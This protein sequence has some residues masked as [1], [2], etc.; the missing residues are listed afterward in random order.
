MPLCGLWF[1][2]QIGIEKAAFVESEVASRRGA[3]ANE[4]P[5]HRMLQRRA[6]RLL[7]KEYP[8]DAASQGGDM[9]ML[10]V[11]SGPELVTSTVPLPPVTD[12]SAE[13]R[14]RIL[15]VAELLF[16]RWSYTGVSIRDVTDMAKTRLGNVNYYFG[17]KQNL[18]FEVLRRRAEVLSAERIKGIEGA[19]ASDLSGSAYIEAL[20]DGYM[21]PAMELSI[22]GGQ[23]WK[24]FFQ[25]IGHITFSRL[26]PDEIMTR[27]FNAPAEKF[28]AALKSRF[29]DASDFQRQAA[30]LLIVGPVIFVLAR[31]GRVETL[32][33]PAF[34]SDDLD[35]L[36]PET[37]RFVVAGVC[38]VM[39]VP[40]ETEA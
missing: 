26:W 7:G 4:S 17:S 22:K 39:K 13:I 37:R 23:G 19:E 9:A 18:Y 36:T 21:M 16:S 32:S 38:A 14:E 2:L 30:A 10:E 6:R 8:V 31:T 15:D 20:V 40:Y 27:Y 12:R 28:V 5:E 34:K 11:P 35:Q 3:G 33:S 24:N 29:P 25:L 1:E